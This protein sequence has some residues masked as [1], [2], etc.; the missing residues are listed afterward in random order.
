MMSSPSSGGVGQAGGGLPLRRLLKGM[1]LPLL[2]R[3][4]L[5]RAQLDRR[6]AVR[7]I[8]KEVAA[9]VHAV[10]FPVAEADRALQ[11][12]RDRVVAFV[13][14]HQVGEF[15]Y[16]Y[17]LSTTRPTLYSSVYACL[18]L[19][20]ISKLEE[21]TVDRKRWA[22]YFDSFQSA[23]DGLFY[24]PVVHNG[25]YGDT[26][27][28]G[29]RHLALHMISAY[30]DLGAKP[31]Y[32]FSFLE[33]YCDLKRLRAWLDRSDWDASFAHEDDVDNKIMNIGSLLQYQRDTW[34]DGRAEEA[35]RYLQHYLKE[36][37]NPETGMWGRWETDDPV[38]R[39]RMVQFAY[40]LY[41]LFF[42]DSQ[43]V[44]HPGAIV[45]QVLK[46][47]S[48]LGGF[49]V[50]ANSSACEDID[51]IYILCRL[52][53]VLPERRA[54]IDEA[55]G[56]ALKWVICNQVEDDGFVFR[57]CETMTYGHQ[58]MS[59]GVNQ[60]AMFP[61]WFRT[62]SLAYLARHFSCGGFHITPAP[63]LEN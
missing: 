60:G 19:S 35:V 26:D 11:T 13:K 45:D 25:L 27:W 59:S 41:P 55:L 7:R 2:D 34:G 37:V 36:R 48:P 46:T 6:L 47:Q 18:T 5:S 61:T 14:R 29:A 33:P 51:S 39:S 1:L 4:G 22:A 23:E 57:L 63:G 49:G 53:P 30:T 28:W 12:A 10:H 62:L 3:V 38:Q 56:R 44:E 40:H 32:P 52:A 8:D 17:A 58:E 24:D 42:Y 31:R 20:L 43:S 15:S 9:R 54:E 50:P 16:L 21:P